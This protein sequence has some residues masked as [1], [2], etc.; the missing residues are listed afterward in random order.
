[1]EPPKVVYGEWLPNQRMKYGG[2]EYTTTLHVQFGC[3]SADH[4][5]L[6]SECRQK[7]CVACPWVNKHGAST[8]FQHK[9]GRLNDVRGSH[10]FQGVSNLAQVYIIQSVLHNTKGGASRLLG[11]TGR[12]VPGPYKHELLKVIS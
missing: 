2:A 5:H 8:S 4:Y 6:W 9:R 12:T 3:L 10:K 11:V 1:M 7:G